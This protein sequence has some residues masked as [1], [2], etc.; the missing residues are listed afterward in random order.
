MATEFEEL[1]YLWVENKK[2]YVKLSTICVY[3]TIVKTHLI[4]FFKDTNKLTEND[5]QRFVLEKLNSGL[6]QKSV[7]DMLVVLKMI[8]RYAQKNRLMSVE[9]M[10]IVFPVNEATKQIEVMGKADEKKLIAFLQDHFSFENFGILI[11]IGTG[12]RI[13][14]ICGLRWD[15]IDLENS[16]I[17]VNRTVERVYLNKTD[18]KTRLIINEPKTVNSKRRIPLTSSLLKIVKPLKRIVNQSFYVISNAEN[19]LEPRVYRKKF[20]LVLE[21]LGIE[22]IKFHSLRHT[23]A[24]RC[25]EATNDFKT[26]SAILG[27]AS[28]T[29]TLNLYVHPNSEQKK[30]CIEKMLKSL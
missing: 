29:T 3:E 25:I 14:E 20:Q 18:E 1:S 12:M 24:T 17:C 30:K 11:C 22:K 7:K 23:F 16:E 21:N 5:V 15:D 6:S 19:P 4:P 28:I 26:V 8:G 9:M 27:H 13:G 10:D 2:L